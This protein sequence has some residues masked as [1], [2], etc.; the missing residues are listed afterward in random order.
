MRTSTETTASPEGL[1]YYCF[2][3]A[4]FACSPRHGSIYPGGRLRLTEDHE[5]TSTRV[6]GPP[7]LP[8]SQLRAPVSPVSFFLDTNSPHPSSHLD[9]WVSG[10][11]LDLALHPE[12]LGSFANS[13]RCDPHLRPTVVLAGDPARE[14]FELPEGFSRQPWPGGPA[15]A[16]SRASPGPAAPA[17]PGNLSEKRT[18]VQ[19]RAEAWSS[20]RSTAGGWPGRAR[21]EAQRQSVTCSPRWPRKTR[22]RHSVTSLLEAAVL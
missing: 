17:L 19:G 21:P 11:A 16:I 12:H 5:A 8:L 9:S 7:L 22:A 6:A 2:T 14:A 20:S 10:R 4:S 13:S 15:T 3:P 1:L 18:L